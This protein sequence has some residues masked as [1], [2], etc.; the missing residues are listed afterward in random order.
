MVRIIVFILFLVVIPARAA[1]DINPVFGRLELAFEPNQGQADSKVKFL[2]RGKGYG[3]FL[4]PDEAVIRFAAPKPSAVR[5][6]FHGQK[7]NPRVEGL[8]PLVGASNYLIGAQRS[9]HRTNVPRYKKV[10]YVD[11]YPGIDVVYYGNQRLLEYDF[12]VRP[13]ADPGKIRIAFSGAEHLTI[14]EGG[15]LILKTR[16]GEMVQRKPRVFQQF[17][18]REKVVDA[19]YVISG[20]HVGFNFGEY[21][22]TKPLVIDP[23][24]I[25]STYFGGTGTGD[26]PYSIAVDSERNVYIAGFT[27]STD[28]PITGGAQSANGGQ[29]DAFVLKLDPTG[30]QAVYATYIGGSAADEAHS[31]AVDAA[32][33][34]YITGFTLSSNFPVVNGFQRTRGGAQ[35]AYV[36]KLNSAGNAILFSSYLGGSADDRGFGIAL[37]PRGNI[38][39]AGA[40]ASSNFPTTSPYQRAN[41]GG[42]ADVFV[43]K[44]DAAANV[45]YSTY[46]GGIGNDQP[47]GIAVDGSGAAYVTGF[48]TSL[49]FPLV[50]PVQ[51]KYGGTDAGGGTDDAFVFKLNSAG[52]ALDYSTYLGGIG[53]DNG[54]R[55]A[56]D[57]AGGAY[58]T[59]M[60]TSVNFPTAKPYQFLPAGDADAF[61]TRLSPDGQSLV[62]STFFG[63]FQTDSG[64][65]IAVDRAG[66]VYVAGFTTSFD[67]PTANEIQN[68]IGGD[69]DGYV[70]KF[71]PDGSTIVF[72]TFLG[73]LGADAA[74]ATAVDADE[75]I[76]V[77]GLTSS[78][79]F[80]TTANPVQA[81]ISTGQDLFI[82]KINA[83]DIVASSQFQVASEGVSSVITR[84][85][86][87][88]AVF[89][90][91]TAEPE[92]PGARLTG[93]AIVSS[94][95]NGATVTEVG[96]PAPQLLE[97]GRL[98][99]D[100]TSEG[101]SVISLANPS[102]EE[103]SVDFVFTDEAGESS[104]ANVKVP[105]HQHFSR[106]VTDEPLLV[107][108]P[109]TLNFTSSIP[110]AATAF[111]TI[112][113]AAGDF[114][115]ST[116][117]IVNP[118]LVT[119]EPVTIPELAEGGGWNTDVILVNTTENQMNGE[120]QFFDQAG[121]PIEVGIG[122][123]TTGASVVEFDIPKRGFQ[124][125]VT[126]GIASRAEVEFAGNTGFSF[127]TAGSGSFQISG[128]ASAEPAASD[129]RLNGLQILE[130]RQLGIVQSHLGLIA[131]ALQQAGR[132][133]VENTEQVRTMIAIANPTYDDVPVEIKLTDDAG[134]S[135]EPV[136]VT[137][138]ARGQYS[139][140]VSEAPISVPTGAARTLSFS[141][142]VSMFATAVRFF[143]NEINDSILT[144]IPIADTSKV[145]NRPVVIPH[146][147]NGAGWTSEIVLVNTTDAPMNGEVR[148][149][150]QGSASDP[151]QGVTVG[152]GIGTASV[153][154]YNIPAG[155]Y[156]RIQTNGLP[157]E[158]NGIA[159]AL[160]VG[161]VWIVPFG[162]ASAPQAHAI[163][164]QRVGGNTIFQTTIGGQVPASSL[165][166]YAEASGDFGAGKM[167]STHTAIALANPSNS[168]ITVRLQL[169]S[170][171]GTSLGTSGPVQIPASGQ[172]AMFLNQVPGFE[173]LRAPFQAVLT[174]NV[175][176]GSGVTAVS[177]RAM[178][179]E[180]KDF[181]FT[182]TGPLNDDA[183]LPG[184]LVFPYMTDGTGY[185][186]QFIL[187]NPP[188]VQNVSGVLRFLAPDASGLQTDVLRLGSVRI[189]PFPGF[190]TPHAHAVLTYKDGGIAAFQT[191][192]EGQLPAKTYRFYAETIGDFESG[193]SGSTR[194]AVAL[195]N[196]SASPV[197]VRLDLTSLDGRLAAAS[198]PIEIPP[199][200]ETAMFVHQVLGLEA[201][202]LPFQGLLRVTTLSGAGVTAVGMRA[203]FNERGNVLFTT[204]GPLVEDAG[205][206]GQLV[207]PHIAEGGGFTTQFI[208]VGAPSGRGGSGVLRFFNQEGNP[209][210]VTLT[211][212]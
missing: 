19:A 209:L 75:N 50:N 163:V 166:L 37:D 1:S 190:E 27:T 188:G 85:T 32:G 154:E 174:V 191:A 112:T 179:N 22:K 72:S 66:G 131:P 111:R 58:V 172:V 114:L 41:G 21:D 51:S 92:Q 102:D 100:F 115:L 148:F 18:G 93:L 152:A 142:S 137:V 46:A 192:V 97:V 25:Y 28:F 162:D 16:A 139:S 95:Q 56:V 156:Q 54:V 122:D 98:F 127:R 5:M 177:L 65:S 3:L 169:V 202:P 78:D 201:A 211:V 199:G 165:R 125:V 57:D 91:G 155:S 123:G 104:F 79:N 176:E 106:F 182:T 195:A 59:G 71:M 34:A 144:A 88:D 130:Y 157:D 206:P 135:S 76:Y 83:R 29:A 35:D 198:R 128:F 86:R 140:F 11:V 204:T 52:T 205:L 212:R 158:E 108:G 43:T 80:P 124:R 94:R 143:T 84:G 208:V 196:P 2:S 126:A 40:T 194:S 26:Q 33:N 23:V 197:T 36:L 113:N 118:Y 189:A 4:T 119:S 61:V 39:I 200:G 20:G 186:T 101:R 105:P 63:G 170:L 90:Y 175:T 96:V 210:S 141:S 89:G 6:K 151:V 193:A 30:T 149:V 116:T 14:G 129:I 173:S 161:S 167:K 74:V 107:F 153:F 203:I 146:F 81:A 120:V 10:R 183:G 99:V 47:L 45:I 8:E 110:L 184:Q 109:G 55:I 77:T 117:P 168:P 68:F 160:A 24:L 180:L 70:A 42:F 159:D 171:D 134:T 53:S 38:Y 9:A 69:R 187:V 48:T 145:V 7:R 178:I 207:F 121:N 150:S 181:I 87:T 103:A 133:F 15:D 60:T 185:T 82:A 44:L 147:T 164:A 17:D 12:I 67:L 49:N 136:I 132:L 138:P 31:V 62:F 73:G 64:T 13:G